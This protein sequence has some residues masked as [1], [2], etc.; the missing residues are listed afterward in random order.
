MGSSRSYPKRF[1]V[2]YSKKTRQMSE[3]N[4]LHTTTQ[5]H[6]TTKTTSPAMFFSFLS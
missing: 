3:T 2:T 5:N 1:S 4:F 6:T